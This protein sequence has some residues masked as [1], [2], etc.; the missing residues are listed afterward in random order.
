MKVC[1]ARDARDTFVETR[2]VF[3]RARAQRVHAE[4]DRIVPG[5]HANEVTNHVDFADF[6]HAF[7]I[8]VTTKF[9]GNVER[10]FVHIERGQTVS[11]APRL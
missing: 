1:E 7:E 5:R 10:D 6:G 9:C 4:V 11:D 8:V 3:H 2:I